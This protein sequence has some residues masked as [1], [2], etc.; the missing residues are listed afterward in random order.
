MENNDEITILQ[1]M[2]SVS[3]VYQALFGVSSVFKEKQWGSQEVVVIIRVE[4]R[5]DV[6]ALALKNSSKVMY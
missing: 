6:L 1:G 4:W 5:P 3:S 2:H